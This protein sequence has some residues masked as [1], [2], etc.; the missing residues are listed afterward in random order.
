MFT[1]AGRPIDDYP[2]I[3]KRVH[4]I[5]KVK[6]AKVAAA[7]RTFEPRVWAT[8]LDTAETGAIA[9]RDAGFIDQVEIEIGLLDAAR[10][11]RADRLMSLHVVA[12]R[13]A[14]VSAAVL[15]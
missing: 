14:E 6:F 9:L 13:G 5:G 7:E 8:L 11:A 12:V 4:P 1:D 2:A 10:F 3:G 15:A